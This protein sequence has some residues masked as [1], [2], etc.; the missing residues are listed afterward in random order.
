MD[1]GIHQGS[2]SKYKQINAGGPRGN[3]RERGKR[4][5]P[6]TSFTLCQYPH[7]KGTQITGLASSST[8]STACIYNLHWFIVLGE[9][10]EGEGDSPWQLGARLACEAFSN[11][12]VVYGH[13]WSNAIGD[14]FDSLLLTHS[15]P[16]WSVSEWPIAVLSQQCIDLEDA[17]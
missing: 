16:P 4:G 2:N 14:L 5:N 12:E 6:I 7:I 15:C 11:D 1:S 8:E 10:W 17:F 13:I 9:D 3:E